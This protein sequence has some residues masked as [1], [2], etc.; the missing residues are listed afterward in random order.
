MKLVGRYLGRSVALALLGDDM[1][2]DRPVAH[3]A[4]IAQHGK[5]M[6]EIVAVDRADI[7]EAELLE[8]G[9]AGPKA[10]GEFLGP[11]RPSLPALGSS[12][13]ARFFRKRR[14]RR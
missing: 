6:I 1:D 3:V 13:W 8:E 10:A 7:I 12:F 9:A 4:H 11:C 5:K 14:R 2:Q